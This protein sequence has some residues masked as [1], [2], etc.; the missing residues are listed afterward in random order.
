MMCDM[1]G[2][3]HRSRAAGRISCRVPSELRL[4]IRSVASAGGKRESAVVRE[5]L[6]EYVE[7]AGGRVTCLD[8]AR[9]AGLIGIVKDL[10][11]DLSAHPRHFRGFGR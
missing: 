8:L 2:K 9:K 5:A 1:R 10:P 4:E 6:E 3:N 11:R 7:S